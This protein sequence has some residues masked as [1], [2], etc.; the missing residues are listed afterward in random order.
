MSRIMRR[1]QAQTVC[2]ELMGL[3]IKDRE[4]A[5]LSDQRS[6][7]LPISSISVMVWCTQATHSPTKIHYVLWPSVRLMT[8]RV[9]TRPRSSKKVGWS[10]HQRTKGLYPV[11]PTSLI[12]QACFCRSFSRQSNHRLI[13]WQR[14]FS[15]WNH[16]DSG[17]SSFNGCV[18]V[19]KNVY[20]ES[21]RWYNV[22]P[23]DNSFTMWD[24]FFGGGEC[25]CCTLWQR[26]L[27]GDLSA[28][29]LL[30]YQT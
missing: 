6:W 4:T 7:G 27:G 28:I 10:I 18:H 3:E 20:K 12:L 1:D 17:F 16:S 14:S 19:V 26:L 29:S 8:Q 15:N 21:N 22:S 9:V 13:S 5:L 11:F 24:I 25:L 2:T 23:Y 30:A